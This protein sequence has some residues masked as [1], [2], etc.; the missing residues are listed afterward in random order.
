MRKDSL[1][2]FYDEYKDEV[3][4]YILSLCSDHYLAQDIMQEVFIK[5]LL[6]LDCSH[7]N[8]KAWLFRVAK[9]LWI[10]NIRK[11]K[12]IST[13]NIEE[14]HVEDKTQEILSN[15]IKSEQ[16]LNLYSKVMNLNDAM[17]EVITL[18]Y[19]L[20]IDQSSIADIMGISNGAVR[21]MLYRARKV[22]KNMMEDV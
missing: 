1:T 5:A 10:D 15:I 22:L 18:Y 4:M 21:T 8:I 3:Y 9:N 13:L 16:H 14:I 19:Y 17:R 6:S 7:E 12:N 20:E 2:K 11:H